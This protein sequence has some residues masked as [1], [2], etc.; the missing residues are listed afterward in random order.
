MNELWRITLLG[1]LRAEQR[2]AQRVIRRFRTQKT[3][4]LLA[5]LAFYRDRNHPRELLIDLL[6]P[7]STVE[8]GRASLGTALSSL[9]RQLEPPGEH[10]G[11]VI[12]TD[13]MNVHLNPDAVTTDVAEF[14]ALIRLAS[15]GSGSHT[16]RVQYLLRASELY[17]GQLLPGYYEDWIGAEQAR[18]AE[19]FAE[20]VVRPL[21][22]HFE[23]AGEPGSAVEHA[24]RGVTAHPMSEEFH[25]D[26]MRLLAAAG[27]P[28]SAISEYRRFERFLHEE[29]AESPSAA[30][31]ALAREIERQVATKASAIGR[32]GSREAEENRPRAG[33]PKGTTRNEDAEAALP[34]GTLTFLLTDIVDSAPRPERRDDSFDAALNVHHALLRTVFLAN[35]GRE[36][37]EAGGSL[38]VVFPRPSRALA[39]AVAGQQALAR[40]D[41]RGSCS[42]LSVRMA[43]HTG[44]VDLSDGEYRGPVL[45]RASRILTAANGGQILCSEATAGLIQQEFAPAGVRLSDLGIYRLR[46]LA[47]PERLFQ[48]EYPDMQSRQFPPLNAEAGYAP[49]LPIAF[50]RFFGREREIG[51]LAVLLRSE[52][53]RLVTMTGTGG[54]GKTRLAL[55]AAR[56]LVEH[57]SGAVTFVPLAAITDSRLIPGAVVDA[58]RIPRSPEVEPLEQM[59]EALRRRPSLLILDNFEQIVGTGAAAVRTLLDRVPDLKVLITSRQLLAIAG[60]R[61]YAV[62][63][64][65][66]PSG[67]G[68]SAEQLGVYESVQLFIDRAQ[69][70]RPDFQITNMSAPAVAALCDRLEGIPLAIELAAAR[71]QVL[72]PGQMLAQLPHRLEFLVSRKRDAIERHRTLRAAID[73]SYRL[74]SPDLQRLFAA[75]SVLNGAWTSETAQALFEKAPSEAADRQ[76]ELV[77]DYLAQLRECSLL[78]TVER[79]NVI[80]FRMMES[81]RDYARERLQEMPDVEARIRLRYA[82]FFLEQAREQMKRFRTIDE[83]ATHHHIESLV[84]NLRTAMAWAHKEEMATLHA[85]IALVVGAL[86][87][88]RGSHLEAVDPVQEALDNM[89]RLRD[90]Q[91]AICAR[92]L[93]ERAGLHLD[94]QE[95]VNARTRAQEALSLFVAANDSEGQAQTE[96]IL[97]QAAMAEGKFDEARQRFARALTHFERASA[98]V[99]AAILY[100]NLGLVE[101]RDPDGDKAVATRNLMAALQ[102]RRNKGD[103]RG[104]AETL[105]N[106]G[107]LAYEQGDMEAAWRWYMEAA[108]YEQELQHTFGEARA[109]ANLGEVAEQ[110]GDS[111]RAIRLFAAAERLFDEVKSSYTSYA[112]GL[113]VR[114]VGSR[115]DAPSALADLRKAATGMPLDTLAGWAMGA[116]DGAPH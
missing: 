74:L 31:V 10:A 4:A 56:R 110:R 24:R 23:Q 42:G 27:Q 80:C 91:A 116:S 57:F 28:E 20:S 29:L 83:A 1:E 111:D 8:A 16:E 69:A 12:N 61:E 60:E 87:Q 19:L 41:W 114:A 107:V 54:T 100:N 81:L 67:P 34:T 2:H 43:V 7:D 98:P 106:L 3:G 25:R 93:R 77:L 45:H 73:W 48:A 78:L 103:R 71:A 35:G 50:T 15:Q 92:L 51:E 82:E 33:L 109:L 11:V 62:P 90:S 86:L 58:M 95:W 112:A 115:A 94:L 105:T 30:T 72:T 59:V 102:L 76:E 97:G 52:T 40:Q 55:E 26:L 70:V 66:M 44:E 88:R 5:Y 68:E 17:G 96:N 64:L 39:A 75:L 47:V 18:L 36:L 108:Q 13:R 84:S 79:E 22:R 49:N 46:D 85:E 101:R 99:D 21:I 9:R 32:L 104:L 53:P 6:W 89:L 14:E 63:P 37:R 38:L 65:T 113:L